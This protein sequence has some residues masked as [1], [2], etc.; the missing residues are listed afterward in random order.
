MF[1]GM[2]IYTVHI[3]PG[4]ENAAQPPLF[5]R[6]G[7]NWL[8][9]LLTG[10]WALYHRLWLPLLLI[11]AFNGTLIAAGNEQLLSRFSLLAV[12]MGFQVIVGFAANDWLRAKLARSGYIMADITAADSR[13]RAEQRYFERSLAVAA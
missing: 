3:K 1:G 13:L 5:V 6:E 10:F 2:K 7:F 12:H 9:F 4:A 8:A 11:L